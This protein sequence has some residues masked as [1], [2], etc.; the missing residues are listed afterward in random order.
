MTVHNA[1]IEACLCLVMRVSAVCIIPESLY[2]PFKFCGMSGFALSQSNARSVRKKRF[3][4][5]IR[6][7][8]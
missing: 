4:F 1:I 6:R 2:S 7:G 8:G 5:A 3:V